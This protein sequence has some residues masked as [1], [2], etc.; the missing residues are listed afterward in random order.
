[1][2]AHSE[3][4]SHQDVTRMTIDFPIGKHKQL[5]AIA[6][7]LGIPMKE[8]I[9]TCVLEKLEDKK[10]LQALEEERD[11]ENFDRGKK[12]IKEEG[13]D[14]LAEVRRYLGLDK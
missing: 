13:Y 12:S 14:T 4:Y 7:L 9:L 10:T 11:V 2:G 1:M 6:A 8:F 3:P 5:K